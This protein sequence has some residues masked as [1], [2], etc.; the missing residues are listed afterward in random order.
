M[1]GME[2][3]LCPR[4]HAIQLE[5]AFIILFM[6]YFTSATAQPK[7]PQ[8]FQQ[9]FSQAPQQ[10]IAYQQRAKLKSTGIHQNEYTKQEDIP[11]PAYGHK[12]FR[13][14]GDLYIGEVYFG[15]T[16]MFKLDMQNLQW[17]EIEPTGDMPDWSP[18]AYALD[19]ASGY[20]KGGGRPWR[21]RV[22]KAAGLR[23]L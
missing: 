9:R 15:G 14:K 22:Q 12:M 13:Y 23:G 17:N 21:S 7:I 19:Y 20:I 5:I 8:Y 16:K 1:K 3:W 18:L 4:F 10:R 11:H 6:L 2:K